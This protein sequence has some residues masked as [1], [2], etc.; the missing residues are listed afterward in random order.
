[1]WFKYLEA[2]ATS[3]MQFTF[4]TKFLEIPGIYFINLR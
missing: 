4:T 2:R 3:R 1:M